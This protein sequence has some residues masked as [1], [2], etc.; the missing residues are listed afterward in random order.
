MFRAALMMFAA[1]GRFSR[2]LVALPPLVGLSLLAA[3]VGLLAPAPRL[4]AFGFVGLDNLLDSAA[5]TRLYHAVVNGN[6]NQRTTG[7][8]EN[9]MRPADPDQPIAGCL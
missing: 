7:A 4:R 5:I 2:L 3:G 8:I 6:R 9:M 1:N